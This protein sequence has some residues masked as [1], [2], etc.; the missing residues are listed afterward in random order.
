M[1]ELVEELE[2][3]NCGLVTGD[4]PISPNARLQDGVLPERTFN[5]QSPMT[6]PPSPVTASAPV[7]ATAPGKVIL[8]GEHGVNRGQPAI[9]ASVGLYAHCTASLPSGR[10]E[11]R[12]EVQ[13][14]ICFRSGDHETQSSREEILALRE[15]VEIWRKD[16]NYECIRALKAKDFFASQKYVLGSMFEEALPSALELV[17]ESEVPAASGLGSGGSA[18]TSMVAA[19]SELVQGGGIK[20]AAAFDSDLQQ[21]ADWAH[22]GDIIAHG[23]IASALDTQTSLFGGVIRF[24]GQGL[25]STI[26]CPPGLKLVI[27]HC[28]VSAPTSEVNTRVRLWLAE[29]SDTRLKYFQTLG[30]L[31]RAAEP[32]LARGDWDELGRLMTLNQLVLEKIGV[33]C[34]EIDRL[35]ET[36]LAAGAYGAKISGSGGG[37]IIIALAPSENK[38]T[39]AA[40][41]A[42]TGV[43][44]FTPKIGVP[45]VTVT[46]DR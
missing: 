13:R 10:G 16:Q 42:Q 38:Q 32:A 21:R 31:T 23:G 6:S 15:Q 28:G 18:F 22:R 26:P 17:W 27:A 4:F 44:V 2:T 36:A 43:K 45:G 5:H 8:F 9:A 11:S 20:M 39:I 30:A 14:G 12:A 25:A 37:G 33:S 35:I 3:G 1:N 41:L 46:T 34:P 40:A 24:T 19:V 29:R 7:T